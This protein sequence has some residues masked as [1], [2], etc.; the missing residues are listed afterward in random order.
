MKKLYK[1]IRH[2]VT[3]NYTIQEFSITRETPK[4]RY[5]APL[6]T[7]QRAMKNSMKIKKSDSDYFET[8]EDAINRAIK[9]RLILLGKAISTIDRLNGELGELKFLLSS[10]LDL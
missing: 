1:L 3:E 7:N 9:S 10:E 8:R 6:N 4:Y 5:I 2:P